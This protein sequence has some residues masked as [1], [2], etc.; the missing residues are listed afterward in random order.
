MFPTF[1]IRFPQR[2]LF[3]TRR[4]W[5]GDRTNH[6]L[7]LIGRLKPGV[8]RQQAVAEMR[9]IIAPAGRRLSGNQQRIGSPR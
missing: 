4:D 1:G 2:P 5:L 6:Y 8:T 9:G 7:S 3:L